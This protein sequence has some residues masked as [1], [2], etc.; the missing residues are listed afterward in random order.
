[1]G[2]TIKIFRSFL[3]ILFF[4]LCLFSQGIE[5]KSIREVE[6]NAFVRP[7]SNPK[8]VASHFGLSVSTPFLE[9]K[10]YKKI[11]LNFYGYDGIRS[12][13]TFNNHKTRYNLGFGLGYKYVYKKFYANLSSSLGI[14]YFFDSD[15]V[16]YE[17]HLGALLLGETHF[18]FQFK[19]WSL[20]CGINQGVGMGKSRKF[21]YVTKELKSG[22][23]FSDAGSL[24][25][26]VG[27]KF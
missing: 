12:L 14:L 7:Y 26:K 16:K 20:G 25:L 19:K 17:T 24:F 5:V 1:M 3:V 13:S 6:I 22:F 27:F 10:F 8:A 9:T 15:E 2:K 21:Y 18:G 4:P 23:S 11:N